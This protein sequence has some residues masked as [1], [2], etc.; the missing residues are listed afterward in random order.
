MKMSNQIF[1]NNGVNGTGTPC[2]GHLPSRFFPVQQRGRGRHTATARVK[3]N[4]E[5]TK[6][7]MECFY[8][9]KPFD[10]EGKP[11]RG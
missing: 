1:E 9:S 10:K 3:L 6:I 7:V 11:I 5:I 8:R 4:K 2:E